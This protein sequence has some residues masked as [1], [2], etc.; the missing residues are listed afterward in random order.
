MPLLQHICQALYDSHLGAAIRESDHDFSIIESV[1]VLS[2]TLLIGMIAVL[3]L[4]M[5]A[6]ILR[7]VPVRRLARAVLPLTWAALHQLCQWF[8]ALLVGSRKKNTATLPS[9]SS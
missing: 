8:S 6:L 9:G 2:I 5:L 3:N 4:R 1:H 7:P